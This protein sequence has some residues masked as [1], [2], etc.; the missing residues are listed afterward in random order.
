MGSEFAFEDI[1]SQEVEKYTYKWIRDEEYQ[2][3]KCF[4]FERY[5]TYKNSGYTRQVVW[6]DQKNYKVL[7]IKFYDRKNTSLKTLTQS[8]FKQYL[9]KFWYPGTMYMENH[10]TGK[11][12][13]ITW[14]DYKFNNGLG[15]KDFD[16]NSLKRAR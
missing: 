6:L 2:N 3:E 9:G 16:K 13:L 15:E 12:T 14:K 8:N 5:P 10:Q 7:Q 11:S 1:T 4:V